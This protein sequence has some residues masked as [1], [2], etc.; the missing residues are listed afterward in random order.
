MTCISEC[1][2][3]SFSVKDI[4]KRDF[5]TEII[6]RKEDIYDYK[7]ERRAHARKI[8]ISELVVLLNSIQYLTSPGEC[9]H[10]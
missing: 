5:I 1:F 9:G 10:E 7:C 4:F 3:F 6:K 8:G 2:S